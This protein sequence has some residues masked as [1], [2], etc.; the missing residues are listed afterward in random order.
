MG[1]P[2]S[3]HYPVFLDLNARL[4]IVVGGGT[5]ALKKAK[6]LKRYGADVTVISADPGPELLAAEAEGDLTVEH[7]EYQRGDLLGATI[8]VCVST[9]PTVRAGVHAEAEG[10]GCPLN[11]Q[12]A[13]EMC[14]FVVPA[15]VNREPLQIAISTGGF[16]PGLARQLKALLTEE[17]GPEWGDYAKLVG[18]S[19]AIAFELIDDA[20]IRAQALEAAG[21][22]ELLERLAGG[23]Q[24]TAAELMKPFVEQ[25]RE[26]AETAEESG[27]AVD[28]SG[29]NA[30]VDGGEATESVEVER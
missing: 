16:A 28:D 30:A 9:D 18:E 22:P 3:R 5:A 15:V 21:A 4:A 25:A 20:D 2:A 10:A 1:E 14:S 8:A 23:E 29:A 27:P 19:R 12:G 6:Q 26:A 7:R 13:P 11:V 17:Y 24:I